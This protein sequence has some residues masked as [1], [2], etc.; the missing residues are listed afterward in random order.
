MD[1]RV[2]RCS[3]RESTLGVRRYSTFGHL[4]SAPLGKGEP[5]GEMCT[6]WRLSLSS[7][8]NG[9]GELRRK[10]CRG[11]F[12]KDG[13]QWWGALTE[14]TRRGLRQYAALNTS[15][16]R[17]SDPVADS[18]N[19]VLDDQWPVNELSNS[20]DSGPSLLATVRRWHALLVVNRI[21]PS[22]RISRS[23][24]VGEGPPQK[25]IKQEEEY[26]HEN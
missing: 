8:S 20:H 2:T 18:P 1:Y 19:E 4:I 16:V 12:G 11:R 14:P 21:S 6:D 25:T 22:D 3:P 24:Y 5:R 15:S 9:C 23:T 26:L 17:G 13:S 7:G 10:F